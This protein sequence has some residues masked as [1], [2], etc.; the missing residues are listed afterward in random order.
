[1]SSSRL[2]STNEMSGVPMLPARRERSPASRRVLWTRVAVVDL[3]FD[4]VMP[5]IRPFRNRKATSISDRTGTPFSLAATSSGMG[6]TPGLGTTRSAS[7][8]DPS[9]WPPVSKA[10]PRSA[11]AR[12]RSPKASAGFFS[13]TLTRA[14]RSRRKRQSASP[15]RSKP[16]TRTFFPRSSISF[17]RSSQFQGRQAEQGE[18]DAQDPE[19]DDHL[20]LRPA[21]ELEMVVEGGHLEDALAL[22]HLEIGDL[23]DDRQRLQDE[24]PGHGEEQE[25]LLDEQGDDGH[26]AAERKGPD[27]AHEHF[28]RVAVVP[29]EAEAGAG[30]GP[31]ED[32]QLGRLRHA[33]DVEVA[34]PV[35]VAR[36]VGQGRQGRRAD[37]G[38]P[39]GQ[40]VQAVGQVDGVGRADQDEDD[41]GHVEPA[42]ERDELLEE[43]EAQGQAELVLGGEPDEDQADERR[44][45]E[46]QSDLLAGAEAEG[47][48]PP[49]LEHVVDEADEAEEDHRQDGD[50]DIE[51]GEI[52]PEQRRDERAEDDDEAAHRGRPLLGV[53]GLGAVGPDLL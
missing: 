24:H 32:G 17:M 34:G 23:E 25:L 3:P 10:T 30:E 44:Q 13:V 20:L 2:L 39:D 48:F 46:L 47:L 52:A 43:R 9:W 37:Q 21:R 42:E 51:V 7:R 6:G 36:D 53:M 40:A 35:G 11:K 41:P 38:Q 8:K 22:A 26:G 49:D 50:P 12:T 15:V 16:T 27:V 28:G 14:P 5:A 18:D 29:E 19:A 31:D 1:M 45:P 33:G 4:P